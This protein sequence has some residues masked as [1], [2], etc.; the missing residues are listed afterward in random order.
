MV[1]VGLCMSLFSVHGRPA[2]P[3]LAAQQAIALPPGFAIHTAVSGLRLPTDMAFLPNGDVLVAEKGSG[4]N[5]EGIARVRLVRQGVLQKEPILEISTSAQIDSGLQSMVL[6]PDFVQN[7][8]FYLWHATGIDSP[9]WNGKPVN[10]LTRYT[11]DFATRSVDEKTAAIILDKVPWNQIHNGGGLAFDDEGNLFIATGDSAGPLDRTRNNAQNYESLGGKL[12]RIRPEPEGGY[13]IPPDNPYVGMADHR[14][15]I[16]AAGFRNPFRMMRHPSEQA[17]F[18]IDVGLDTWE[19]VNLVE[20]GANY[21]WP[22]REGPCQ[23]ATKGTACTPTPPEYTDPVVAYPLPETGGAVT[24][25]AFYGGTTFP[26]AY[27]NKM[28]FTDF[29]NRL[30]FVA[31]LSQPE[32]S[33]TRFATDTGMYVDMEATD[34]AIY[35]LDIIR[36]TVVSLVYDGAGNQS[37]VP[38]LSVNATMGRAP[39]T[40]SFSAEGTYDP[41]DLGVSYKWDFGDGT[42]PL[43]TAEPVVQHEYAADGNYVATLQAF[44]PR[45]GESQILSEEI[46]V[47]SGALPTVV[48]DVQQEPGRLRYRG[49]DEIRFRV[50]RDGGTIGLDPVEPYQWDVDLHH[51]EHTHPVV[52]DYVSDSVTVTIP[53][54]SHALEPDIWYEVRLV[55]KTE[56]GIIVHAAG[57]IHPDLV[58]VELTSWPGPAPLKINQLRQDAGTILPVIVGQSYELEAPESLLLG[59]SKGVFDYWL[60]TDGWVGAPTAAAAFNMLGDA[61]PAI[62]ADGQIVDSRVATVTPGTTGK[63]YIAFYRYSGPAGRQYLPMISAVLPQPPDESP[64]Q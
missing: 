6:D 4:F 11:Y 54:K 57:E 20:S 62:P 44:D 43:E 2:H 16:Y 7:G 1:L 30:L 3:V 21:G 37:P 24:T 10:R 51:N 53:A 40:V 35:M 52:A 63:T 31:D 61:A 60:V 46:T 33:Y 64:A 13:S 38:Q 19:E 39:M 32:A 48:V 14:P 25:M 56:G 55:M 58:D 15:E 12:L 26:E 22:V 50:N 36:G 49:G 27:R 28:F 29:N 42:P 17:F 23:L 9:G 18:L 5:E 41:D 47:Y 45:G 8:Y 34:S 59:G